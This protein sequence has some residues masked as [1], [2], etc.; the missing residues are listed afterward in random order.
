MVNAEKRRS[1]VDLKINNHHHHPLQ[2][3]DT[4]SDT[5]IIS[6][7]TWEIIGKPTLSP[8]THSAISASGE[9]V[10]LSGEFSCEVTYGIKII[11]V[12]CHVA[13][14]LNLN[15]LRNDWLEALDILKQI[16][17]LLKTVENAKPSPVNTLQAK[18]SI[19]D[20]KANH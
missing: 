7:S 15:L 2:E 3:L 20:L 11:K 4:A 16:S 5:T 10:K 14:N 1:C 8:Q 13:E 6:K 17:E 9:Q 19:E 12:T 18:G